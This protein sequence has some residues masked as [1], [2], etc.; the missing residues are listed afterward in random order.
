MRRPRF[1]PGLPAD[2]AFAPLKALIVARTGHHY[3]VDK[4]EL[5]WERLSRRLAATGA[6]DC[7]VYRAILEDR[8]AGPGEWAA[9]A[10]E[11]TI[12]ETFFFRYADQFAALRGRILPDL[13]ARRADSRQLRIWSAGCATGAEPYSLAILVCELLGE[14]LEDW[15]VSIVGTDINEQF[16]KTARAATFGRW[17]LRSLSPEEL[18]SYFTPASAPGTWTLR[19]RYRAMVQFR[20]QNLMALIEGGWPLNLTDFDLILCRNVLIYFRHDV[21][22]GIFG[23][24]AGLLKDDG[25]MLIG[26]AEPNPDFAALAD[27]VDL[28][29]TVAYRP[30][31][32]GEKAEPVFPELEMPAPPPPSTPP[33]VRSPAKRSRAVAPALAPERAAVLPE[34]AADLSDAAVAAAEAVRLADGGDLAGAELH[35][36]AAIARHP[37]DPVLRLYEGVI[38]RALGSA[39]DA[40]TALR[41]AIYLDRDLA[42]AHYQL[43][44]LLHSEG[45]IVAARRSFANAG[46]LARRMELDEEVLHLD[47]MTAGSLRDLVKLALEN[48]PLNGR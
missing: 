6:P 11:I 28:P 16:L 46:N 17:P 8:E 45:R 15:R 35:C 12:G 4:D 7:T 2:P 36:R 10:A 41:R 39:A 20:P 3:Y 21:A 22:C 13:I 42:A 40:E 23:G 26:H 14:A 44:L 27:T 38:A 33:R 9:L 43:A 18:E 32:M 5:L 24:L 47:G 25:W 34:I 31:G 19:P 1:N 30:R 29:G 37:M 48:K